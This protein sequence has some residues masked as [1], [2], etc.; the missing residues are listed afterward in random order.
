[1][2]ADRLHSLAA[3]R[4]IPRELIALVYSSGVLDEAPAL[5]WFF[6]TSLV[7]LAL[8]LTALATLLIG[9]ASQA[10][11]LGERIAQ[12]LP[13]DVHA[14]VTNLILR[15]RRD[16][17]LLIIGSIV[18]MM[19]TSSGAVGV[20]ARCLRR[21][22]KLPSTGMIR[23]KLRNVGIAGAVALLIVL[24]VLAASAG[25]GLVR[26]LHLPSLV[27]RVG[28]LV[29]S[30]AVTTAICAAVLLALS[31]GALS[32]HAA[33]AGGAVAG[34]VLQLTPTVAG[35]YLRIVAGGTPVEL[36]LIMAGVLATCYIASLGLLL[37]AAVA[38]RVHLGLAP[39]DGVC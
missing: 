6:V 30:V 16:S 34:V 10:E 27:T 4:R 24:M 14:E 2:R 25:T 21:V 35:Y 17:P 22:A 3:L 29:L 23:G 11:H 12:V 15:T 37:G 28:L 39:G 38:G 31:D 19:W 7:P 5:S 1:M 26:E 32:R 18:V 20:L 8:G 36:F 33:L 13:K 9:D